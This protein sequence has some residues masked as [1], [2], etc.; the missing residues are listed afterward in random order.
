ME[1][2]HSNKQHTHRSVQDKQHASNSN[3]YASEAITVHQCSCV[4]EAH[5]L[6]QEDQHFSINSINMITDFKWQIYAAHMQV[7]QSSA[8]T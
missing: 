5:Q 1:Q 8:H 2:S 7:Q 4:H 3:S 6:N